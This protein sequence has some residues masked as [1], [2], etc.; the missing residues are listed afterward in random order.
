M[1]NA[2]TSLM[3]KTYM[4][5]EETMSLQNVI[6]ARLR[7]LEE[8]L[9]EIATSKCHVQVYKKF[10]EYAM[11]MKMTGGITE[12]LIFYA[13]PVGFFLLIVVGWYPSIR[14]VKLPAKSALL[15]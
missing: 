8:T 13:P 3:L 4:R 12:A 1:M 5:G 14:V 2:S 10:V 7:S 6:T 11:W 15:P 9:D